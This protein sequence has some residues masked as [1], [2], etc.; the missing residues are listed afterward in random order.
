MSTII[1]QFRILFNYSCFVVKA[2]PQ[3][4]VT[5]ISNLQRKAIKDGN[6]RISFS[7][8]EIVPFIDLYWES[9]TTLPRKQTNTWYASIQ[10]TLSNHGNIF[11]FEDNGTD[12]LFGLVN[13]DLTLIKPNYE[14]L[15]KGG[16][17]KMNEDGLVG[18]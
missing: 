14:A 2:L 16:T 17:L 18:M 12:Q 11:S 13:N 8:K 9:I 7:H 10:K 6:P 4:C 15:I 3:M 1:I 5:A